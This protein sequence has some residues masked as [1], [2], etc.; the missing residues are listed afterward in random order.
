M[1]LRDEFLAA[2]AVPFEDVDVN[3]TTVRVR[4]LTA[5]MQLQVEAVSQRDAGDITFWILEN[6]LLDPETGERLFDDGDPAVRDLDGLTIANL[7]NHAMGLSGI[8]D[9][10]KNSEGAPSSEG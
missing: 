8:M 10:A 2:A 6:C 1:S 3:G 4:A 9:Q 7:A 5:A